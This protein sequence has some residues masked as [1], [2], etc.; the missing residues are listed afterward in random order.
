MATQASEY[1]VKQS[2][3]GFE[4]MAREFPEIGEQ[5]KKLATTNSGVMSCCGDEILFNPFYFSDNK[6]LAEICQQQRKIGF[7][8]G[9]SSLQSVGVHESAHALEWVLDSLNPSNE[10]DFQKVMAYRDCLEAKEIVSQACKNIKK[11]EYGKGKRNNELIQSISTYAY[12]NESDTLAEAFADCYA[13]GDNA[14]P[15]SKE[16][17]KLTVEKYKAYREMIA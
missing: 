11:T 2:L 6:K 16:I 3:A 9:N 4:S 5:V 15:L 10:Y 17:R 13:N 8:P 7:W 12:D 14:N 1:A